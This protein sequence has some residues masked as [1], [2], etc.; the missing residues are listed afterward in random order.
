MKINHNR[1]W[2]LALPVDIDFLMG[3]HVK[4][5]LEN[6]CSEAVTTFPTQ[7]G[8]SFPITDLIQAM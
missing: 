5:I 2:G 3:D 1:P 4:E 6:R 8:G 7:K